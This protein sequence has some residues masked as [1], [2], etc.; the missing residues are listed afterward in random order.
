LLRSKAHRADAL[1]VVYS[2]GLGLCLF[3][4]AAAIYVAQFP[5]IDWG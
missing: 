3:V 5:V 4:I 1:G 2:L